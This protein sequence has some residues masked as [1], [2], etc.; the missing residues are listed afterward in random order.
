[1]K[2][3]ESVYKQDVIEIIQIHHWF[4]LQ[5]VYQPMTTMVQG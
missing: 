4:I 5:V 2:V 3:N 1:M